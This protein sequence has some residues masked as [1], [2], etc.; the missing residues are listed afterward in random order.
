MANKN[1]KDFTLNIDKK[2]SYSI[3]TNL[4]KNSYEADA[5]KIEIRPIT[6]DKKYIIQ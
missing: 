4:I 5:T 1:L 6:I 3:F 2:H